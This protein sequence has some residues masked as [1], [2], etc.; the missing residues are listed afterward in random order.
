MPKVLGAALAAVATLMA[1]ALLL[2]DSAACVVECRGDEDCAP[3]FFRCH[4]NQCVECLLADDCATLYGEKRQCWHG[5][6]CS[7]GDR[8]CFVHEP[9]PNAR[10][11]TIQLDCTMSFGFVPDAVGLG[12]CDTDA[13]CPEPA[14]CDH[15]DLQVE[16]Q[17]TVAPPFARADSQCRYPALPFCVEDDC[18]ECRFGFDCVEM[19]RSPCC[20]SGNITGGTVCQPPNDDGTCC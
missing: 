13:D 11:C 1:G 20:C 3:P 17:F 6:C 7:Q 9:P 18:G 10:D 14:V 16:G 8:G 5:F 4:Q 15:A 19:G 12:G 2:V